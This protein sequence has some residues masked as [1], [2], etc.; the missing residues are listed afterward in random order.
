MLQETHEYVGKNMWIEIMWSN[1]TCVIES[2]FIFI[3]R[4]LWDNGAHQRAKTVI[5]LQC[6]HIPCDNK[7]ETIMTLMSENT[8]CL[9]LNRKAIIGNTHLFP[10]HNEPSSMPVGWKLW[11][12]RPFE[13]RKMSL[14]RRAVVR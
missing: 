4:S 7:N 8:S 2:I 3:N 1:V 12:E 11:E 10:L 6:I 14:L 13:C 5:K 9:M